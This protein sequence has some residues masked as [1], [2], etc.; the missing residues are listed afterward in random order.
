MVAAP[1]D[2][3]YSGPRVT[4]DPF[5]DAS[6]LGNLELQATAEALAYDEAELHDLDWP[7]S[8]LAYHRYLLSERRKSLAAELTRRERLYA[9]GRDVPNPR[10]TDPAWQ[11]LLANRRER[12]DVPTLLTWIGCEPKQ[13][14]RNGPRGSEEYHGPCPLCGGTDRFMSWPGGTRHSRGY[15]RQCGASFDALELVLNFVPGCDSFY[16]AVGYLAREL[17]LPLPTTAQASPPA[18]LAPA[19]AFEP[20]RLPTRRR[21]RS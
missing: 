14:G 6:T 3:K 20:V 1:S 4:L 7:E 11:A 12:A 8:Q 17:G 13:T 10:A 15:C 5:A 18:A 21:A 16:A 2:A 19:A 9:A